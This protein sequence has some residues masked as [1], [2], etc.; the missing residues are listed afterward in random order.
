M[1]CGE[2]YRI[3]DSPNA[4][5]EKKNTGKNPTIRTHTRPAN[6]SCIPLR[7]YRMAGAANQWKW[8][9]KRYMLLFLVQCR[10]QLLPCSFAALS[11][12]AKQRKNGTKSRIFGALKQLALL[13]KT[14]VNWHQ[15]GS[16]PCCSGYENRCETKWN[17]N[18]MRWLAVGSGWANAEKRTKNLHS[19]DGKSIS[20]SS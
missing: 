19:A 3:E 8:K 14:L 6:K 16:H 15:Y 7:S 13:V 10:A 1:K 4:I 12:R 17:G 2:S 20:G 18:T 5:K 11:C 9:E